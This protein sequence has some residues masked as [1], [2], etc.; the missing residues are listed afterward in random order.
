ED[1][2]RFYEEKILNVIKN[3]KEIDGIWLHLHGSMEVINIGAGE[4]ELL[5]NI[6]EIV[7]NEIPISLALD[8]HANVDDDVVRLANIIRGYR[9]APHVDQE[10]TEKITANLLVDAI[11][12]NKKIKPAFKRIHMIT[13]G[14]KATTNTEPM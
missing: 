10:E 5:R 13:P 2:Y 9:T 4:A 12:K 3:E 8:L 11:E 1:A 7:G 6:R 14:E